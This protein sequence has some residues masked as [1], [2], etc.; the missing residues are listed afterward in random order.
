MV[1]FIV[2]KSDI[3]NNYKTQNSGASFKSIFNS[4]YSTIV[5]FLESF[6]EKKLNGRYGVMVA[7]KVVDLE[8]RVQFPV[9]ALLLLNFVDSNSKLVH[10]HF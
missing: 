9:S 6:S 7:Y 5:R 3:L 4:F 10:H 8:A 1:V 2:S